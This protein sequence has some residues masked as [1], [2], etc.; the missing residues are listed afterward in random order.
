MKS[1]GTKL[2]HFVLF[3]VL[4][5]MCFPFIACAMGLG[6]AGESFSI[7]GVIALHHKSN[8]FY[9]ID[10]TPL[11]LGLLFFII[12][13]Y[14]L[15]QLRYLKRLSIFERE[16]RESEFV[17]LQKIALRKCQDVRN[18]RLCAR[19]FNG[20]FALSFQFRQCCQ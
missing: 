7:E 6:E 8:L 16:L 17:P 13:K 12:G 10:L 20:R 14:S 11:L 1:F 3:G 18:Y 19:L 5:G 9:I 4:F 2:W 15:V